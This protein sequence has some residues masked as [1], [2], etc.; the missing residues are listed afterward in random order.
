MKVI[1]KNFGPIKRVEFN[2]EKDLNI[3][4][5]KNNI[6]KSYAITALYIIIKHLLSEF[7]NSER[8]AQHLYARQRFYFAGIGD[9]RNQQALLLSIAN[10][11]RN[12]FRKKSDLQEYDLSV[13]LSSVLHE[14]FASA[15]PRA[16]E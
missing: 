15:L 13:S 2:L 14:I 12:A 9:S 6:G 1:L 8:Y 11:A 10:E 7:V 3:I 16:F 4:F 5:G